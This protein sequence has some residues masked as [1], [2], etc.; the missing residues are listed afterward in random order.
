MPPAHT[1][2]DVISMYIL[3]V[4]ILLGMDGTHEVIEEHKAIRGV[5][6]HLLDFHILK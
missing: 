1:Y 3:P 2:P 5:P 6:T 4:H